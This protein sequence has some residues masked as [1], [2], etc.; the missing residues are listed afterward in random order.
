MMQGNPTSP[1][2]SGEFLWLHSHLVRLPPHKLPQLTAHSF[3]IKTR[4]G[5]Q[6]AE[7]ASL[8]QKSHK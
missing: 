6:P 5:H 7:E 4:A 1:A 8:P 2:S 3:A